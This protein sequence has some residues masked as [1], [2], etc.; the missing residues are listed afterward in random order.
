[1]L[2]AGRRICYGSEGVVMW[3]VRLAWVGPEGLPSRDRSPLRH[4]DQK[5]QGLER[6]T[7]VGCILGNSLS[8]YAY[9]CCVC[10]S[11]TSENRG[12]APA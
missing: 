1:M 11:G 12:K 4:M 7:C 3:T 2:W 6:H 8:I 10:V 9:S 5:G